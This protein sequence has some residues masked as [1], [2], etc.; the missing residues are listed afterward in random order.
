M[1]TPTALNNLPKRYNAEHTIILFQSL[2]LTDTKLENYNDIT[3]DYYEY[4]V[5]KPS[6]SKK[7]KRTGLGN[8][9]G[10]CI[11]LCFFVFVVLLA[12]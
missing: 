2:L 5:G 9:V 6:A 12:R 7:P 8:L 11:Q 3:L 1:A 10:S 4:S